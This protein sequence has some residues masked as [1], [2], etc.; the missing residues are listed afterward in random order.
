M[1]ASTEKKLRQ[2]AREA[3]TDKKLLAQ[4]EEA[5]KK[6]QSKL[7]W[8]LGTIAVI[9]LIA[10]ILFLNSGFFYKNTTALTIGDEK[11]SPAQVNYQY[12]TEY[13]NTANQY[14]SYASLFGLDTSTGL[15]GLDKQ[16][17]PMGDGSTWKDYFLDAAKNDLIQVKALTDYAEANG[18]ALDEEDIASVDEGF[19]GIDEHARSLGFAGADNFFAANYGNGVDQKLARRMM[20]SNALATKAYTAKHD[21]IDYSAQELEDY[22]QSLEGSRDVYDLVYYYVAAAKNEGEDAPSQQAMAEAQ[23]E[24]DAILYAYKDG[25]DI[26]D[27]TE[28]FSVAV[29]PDE[30]GNEATVLS[31]VTSTS[32]PAAIRDWL[33][34]ERAEGDVTTA[35]DDNGVYAALFLARGDNH[36]ATANVRHILIRAEA[37]EDGSYSKEALAAA[38]ARA[39]EILDEFNAGDKSEESFATL[40]NLY[41]EDTGSNTNGG[42]YENVARGQMVKEFDAFCFAGHK[43][44]D[45]AIVYGENAGYAGY[46][47][48][49]YVGDGPLYSDVIA[50]SDLLNQDMSQWLTELTE[51]YEAVEGFGYRF[52]G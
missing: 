46:H 31:A 49:Y 21:S 25:D 43:S 17:S 5:K 50:R 3:G 36:Y 52:V 37:G 33:T 11:F 32:A 6:A 9:L 34:A 18:I 19:E 45:T 39:Q 14:G 47:V 13:L 35:A 27:L 51:A 42:L 20:L 8:T 44:G 48:V 2:A 29:D 7:R 16:E 10:V 26:A 24:A 1:S 22:Y 30:L 23:A 40:A 15:S 4:Q 38:K 12:A 41:S 28:R